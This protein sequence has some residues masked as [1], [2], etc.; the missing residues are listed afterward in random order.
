MT[1]SSNTEEES[2][3]NK[4][5]NKYEYCYNYY[6]KDIKNRF[7]LLD[8]DNDDTNNSSTTTL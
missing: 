5:N 7:T 6:L 2:N 1:P 3:D 4:K 8:N